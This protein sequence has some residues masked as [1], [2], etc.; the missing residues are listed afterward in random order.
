M[1]VLHAYLIKYNIKTMYNK[2]LYNFSL[3]LYL[4]YAHD[5]GI[6]VPPVNR[7]GY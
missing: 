3:K 7:A 5:K 6:I 1:N 4:H 2:E